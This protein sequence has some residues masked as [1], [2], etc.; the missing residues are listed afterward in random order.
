M[1]FYFR[2][3]IKALFALLMLVI[4]LNKKK[5]ILSLYGSLFNIIFILL[6]RILVLKRI[7]IAMFIFSC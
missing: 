1:Q 6:K 5:Q 4:K 3:W 2:I 7:Y